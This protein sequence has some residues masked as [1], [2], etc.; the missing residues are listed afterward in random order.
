V[1]GFAE[2]FGEALAELPDAESLQGSDLVD[3]VEFHR[4][5]LCAE[6]ERSTR[7]DSEP[8]FSE[9]CKAIR[10][11]KERFIQSRKVAV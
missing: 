4:V 5:L 10:D 6:G 2:E 7:V 11:K 8:Q 9:K 3:D 1:G